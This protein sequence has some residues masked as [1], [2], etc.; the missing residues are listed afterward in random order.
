MDKLV[1]T[2]IT[3]TCDTA[4]DYGEAASSSNLRGQ[5]VAPK[6]SDEA[7]ARNEVSS[8]SICNYNNNL[9]TISVWCHSKPYCAI[10]SHNFATKIISFE[11]FALVNEEF[12]HGIAIDVEGKSEEDMERDCKSYDLKCPEYCTNCCTPSGFCCVRKWRGHCG[13]NNMQSAIVLECAADIW[14]FPGIYGNVLDLTK[15]RQ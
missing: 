15:N 7:V 8:S 6:F 13:L 14:G 9:C 3:I 12:L 11:Q 1:D 4:T 5:D 10:S 2:A